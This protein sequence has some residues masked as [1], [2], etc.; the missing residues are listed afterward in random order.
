[1][2]VL[3][4]HQNF[5]GQFRHLAKGL[6]DAG[7]EVRAVAISPRQ[8][9][10]GV[11][12][13]RYSP[14]RSSTRGIHPWA[15][16][17][18]T[19][20]IRAEACARKMLELRAAGFAPDLVIGH[21]G[22]G[23]TWLLDQ[24]WPSARLL[25][26]QEFHYGADLDFDPEFPSHGQEGC[27]RFQ[28]KNYCLLPGLDN[29]DW[30][31][32]PTA[33]QRAQFPE[34]YR[35]R[36]SVAFEGIDTDAVCPKAVG[37]LDLGT[38][39]VHLERGE[40]IVTFVNRNLE[41]YRGYHV[42]MRSLPRL[43]ALRPRA[44]VVIVGGDEIGYGSA[45]PSGTW[46]ERYLAEVRDRIDLGRVHFV[47]KVPYGVLLDLFRIAT[48]H[49]YFTYPFVLSWSMLEAMSTGALVVGSRTGPVEEVIVDG[50]NGLL[51]DFFDH[52]GLAARVAE[53]LAAPARF[54]P[55]RERARR[56]VL[57]RYALAHCL[58]RQIAIASAVREGA[59]PPQ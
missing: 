47:G 17:F 16:D 33:W 7:N 40:E 31:M 28:I 39:P 34:R 9:I 46:R 56:T 19:K 20:T 27:F 59:A 55:L 45:P 54:E 23:E 35:E 25:C 1:M 12:I 38:P 24:V 14:T 37:A 44:R 6:A 41:P 4:V 5:P 13:D 32:S 52:E 26:L 29:M 8:S 58:P 48:C 22:W 3:F 57:D 53:V 2:R 18:E 42:F 36:I 51:V 10:A 11:E 43:L 15:V 21:P 49:V 30:G 50:E